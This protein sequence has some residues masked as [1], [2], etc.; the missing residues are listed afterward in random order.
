MEINYLVLLLTATNLGYISSLMHFLPSS[1]FTQ[2][3]N[4]R[5]LLIQLP[6]VGSNS[7]GIGVGRTQGCGRRWRGGT[8]YVADLRACGRRCVEQRNWSQCRR[9]N[10]LYSQGIEVLTMSL[11]HRSVSRARTTPLLN[12]FLCV[13]DER[14]FI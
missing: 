4:L 10:S 8:F 11:C 5:S 6:L 3:I 7:L 12:G 1:F 13:G 9:P 2:E 14:C